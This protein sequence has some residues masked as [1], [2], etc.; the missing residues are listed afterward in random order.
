MF[1]YAQMRTLMQQILRIFIRGV[2]FTNF[3]TFEE[4]LGLVLMQSTITGEDIIKALQK[5]TNSMGIGIKKIVSIARNVASV[6]N[7]MTL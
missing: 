1:Q 7:I 2:F 6:T 4:F 5:C 3:D